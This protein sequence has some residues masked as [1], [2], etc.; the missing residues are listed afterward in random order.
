MEPFAAPDDGELSAQA[1]GKGTYVMA[2]SDVL[3][4]AYEGETMTNRSGPF[5]SVFT[6]A[7]IDGLGTGRAD[8]DND[9]VITAHELFVHIQDQVRQ[10]G[11]PQTPTEFTSGVQGNIPI[12][13][14]AL[15]HRTAD[16]RADPFGEESLPLG[17]LPLLVPTD[18]RGLCAPGWPR[19]GT[20]AVPL[21]RMYDPEHGLRETLTLD[22]SGGAAHVGIVGGMWSGKTSVLRTLACSLALTH[23]PWRRRSTRCTASRTGWRGWPGCRTSARSPTTRSGTASGRSSRRG[24]PAEPWEQVCGMLR[25]RSPRQ[26]RA[27]RLRG[28]IP[29]DKVGEVFLLIDSWPDFEGRYPSSPGCACAS[30]NWAPTT[31]C[32]SPSRPTA[33]A[34]SRKSCFPI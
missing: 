32:T 22:L 12:A 9:G 4:F 26:F 25:I 15:W 31:G 19:N 2:A 27:R 29:G 13:R 33:G 7:I 5:R 28:E 34:T 16:V 11:V 14:A 23:S 3:E 24:G 30:H 20:F 10:S 8:A 21:G 18:D 6:E 1:A 17:E